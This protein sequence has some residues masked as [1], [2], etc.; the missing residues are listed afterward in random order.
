[1]GC[2]S[3]RNS[4]TFDYPIISIDS[5]DLPNDAGQYGSSTDVEVTVTTSGSEPAAIFIRCNLAGSERVMQT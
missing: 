5:V 1:M 3:F 2:L 4:A